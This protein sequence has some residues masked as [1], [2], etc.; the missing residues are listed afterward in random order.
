MGI[1]KKEPGRLEDELYVLGLIFMVFGGIAFLI[2]YFVFVPVLPPNAC[3]FWKLF[4]IYCPGCGGT[5]AV[6]ALLHGELG[7]SIWYHPV[8]LYTTVV[9]GGFMLTH[10]LEK[11]SVLHIKG[12]KFHEWYLYGALVLIIV[13]WILK[14]VLLL[15]FNIIL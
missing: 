14:N 9:F 11:F 7:K 3:I 5:R 2:Y 1:F 12:W 13:N 8:V 10:T 15:G 4:H 6:R